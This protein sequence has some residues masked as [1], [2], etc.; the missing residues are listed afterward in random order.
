MTFPID[1]Y[2]KQIES[3]YALMIQHADIAQV[4]LGEDKW[5]LKEMVGHLID[6]AS[7]NHQRFVRLQLV[8]ELTFPPYDPEGWRTVSKANNL[9]YLF[10]IDFW[11]QYN[12]FLLHLIQNIDPGSLDHAWIVNSE[13]KPLRFLIEDYF[14]H[15]R[16]HVDLFEKR[17]EEIRSMK[18]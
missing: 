12:L 18:G 13:K 14:R 6:S 15:I 2:R 11:K 7:N 10:L 3:F 17:A 4:K 9:D 1:E 16:W 8:E 5:T